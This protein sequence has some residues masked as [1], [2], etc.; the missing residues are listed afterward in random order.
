[1]KL[2]NSLLAI[3]EQKERGNYGV[4]AISSIMSLLIECN[5]Q[6]TRH[7]YTSV[8]AYSPLIVRLALCPRLY[9]C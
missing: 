3:P 6:S 1:M 2:G 9:C 7:L 5:Q 4:V 8:L